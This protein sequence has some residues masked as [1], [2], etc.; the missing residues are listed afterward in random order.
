MVAPG[1]GGGFRTS[2][3][4]PRAHATDPFERLPSDLASSSADP[5]APRL[6]VRGDP[7]QGVVI[8][9][10]FRGRHGGALRS[11]YVFRSEPERM[12]ASLRC[13][14]ARALVAR[15]QAMAAQAAALGMPGNAAPMPSMPSLPPIM[16][17]GAAASLIMLLNESTSGS[18]H[19]QKRKL[20]PARAAAEPSPRQQPARRVNARAAVYVE[21]TLEDILEERT[22][23]REAR[24]PKS[25]ACDAS[26]VLGA[27]SPQ[28]SKGGDRRV[29]RDAPSNALASPRRSRLSLPEF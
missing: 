19:K 14:Q 18:N 11:D 26:P 2:L 17:S 24:G 16:H 25:D 22:Q 9:D 15:H 5:R 29:A 1:L 4:S 10:L 23:P 27:V 7:H 3:P 6:L 20:V 13:P 28:H 21:P 12:L 8:G